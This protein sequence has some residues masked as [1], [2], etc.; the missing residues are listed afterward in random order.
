MRTCYFCRG[1]IEKAEADY[2]ALR[3]F[4]R[5]KGKL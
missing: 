3:S 1:I 4:K 5:P 2:M